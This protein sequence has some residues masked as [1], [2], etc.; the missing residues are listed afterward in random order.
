MRFSTSVLSFVSYEGM[1][2]KVM[3]RTPFLWPDMMVICA[4]FIHERMQSNNNYWSQQNPFNV[5]ESLSQMVLMEMGISHV[6]HHLWRFEGCQR[7]HWIRWEGTYFNWFLQVFLSA[8]LM[9]VWCGNMI[10]DVTWGSSSFQREEVSDD[11]CNF[12]SE[13]D[14]YSFSMTWVYTAQ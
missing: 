3:V 13:S 8:N 2:S 9:L 1:F 12:T 10:L 7:F 6:R 11:F 4:S 5:A 14:V